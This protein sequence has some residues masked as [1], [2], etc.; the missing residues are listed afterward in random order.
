[1]TYPKFIIKKSKDNQFYFNLHAV[2]AEIILTSERYTSLQGCT[3]GIASVQKNAPIDANYYRG[4]A[5]NGAYYFNLKA[6]NHQNIGTSEMY[7]TTTAR[8]NGIDAVKRDAPRA[9]ITNLS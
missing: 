6:Q 7:T 9:S 1:M 4:Q 5:S 2:N 3:N 8:D